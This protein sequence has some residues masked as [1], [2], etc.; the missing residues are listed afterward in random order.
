MI[1]TRWLAA[2]AAVAMLPG[3]TAAQT[4]GGMAMPGMK[5]PAK[6]AAKAKPK[7][8]AK[9][10]SRSG[11]SHAAI[12]RNR[13]TPVRKRA[14]PAEPDAMPT[15]DKSTPTATD[16]MP[17]MA[18]PASPAPS[19]AAQSMPGMTAPETPS[20]SA[21]PAAMPGMDMAGQKQG[22]PP[23]TTGKAAAGAMAG[24]DMPGMREN[25]EADMARDMRRPGCN[26][27]GGMIGDSMIEGTSCFPGEG[28][29]TSRL[30]AVGGEMNGLH[31][32][33]GKWM[34]MVHG[35]AWG[36]YTAQ[37]GPRGR[38]QAFSTSM[39]MLT[40]DRDL[41][42]GASLSL[43]TMLSLDALMGPR[44]YPSLFATGETADGVTP[45][46]DRQH[47][48]D[49]FMELAAKIDV[50]LAGDLHGFLY[51]GPVAE[52]ALGPSA[53]MHRTTAKYLPLAPITHHWFDSTH[54]TFGVVTAGLD[55]KRWQFEGSTFRG[56]E[57][58]EHRWDIET[59]RLDSW[60][61]RATW[62]PSRYWSAQVSH[63]W[64]KSPE[65]LEP[66]QNEA[67]TTASVQYARGGFS[68]LAG[69]AVKNRL[70]GRALSAWLGEANWDVN[71]HHSVFGRIENL[72]NDEL[73]PNPLDPLHDRT[74]RVT[75][76][77]LG[78]AY[79]V[80]LGNHVEAA[81][82][83]SGFVVAKPDALDAAYGKSP[84]GWTG[85]V[86]LSLGG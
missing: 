61:L 48:H 44:G 11:A 69:F 64:L 12:V 37:S 58:D 74:F 71:K 38:D 3:M 53:F 70:P 17:G 76:A 66:D 62:N 40:A 28:S 31:V 33:T 63:G 22:Q 83:G 46:V 54:I 21:P 73:F 81:I 52:P 60:S 13:K 43:R 78:Y 68:A 29:G 24:M 2:A 72:A 30:P 14:A 65:A 80:P 9:P 56:R 47:P 59:P 25:D 20:S 42:G 6:P 45:L 4:M 7:N 35:Y 10:A 86:K 18:M 1:R 19:A 79:R 26:R 39:A 82:G 16:A 8:K 57:P 67:R 51:G 27:F 5:M 36:V 50:P 55:T 84:A 49:L 32:M 75:R 15:M 77:E 41:G 34:L 85:F 23:A